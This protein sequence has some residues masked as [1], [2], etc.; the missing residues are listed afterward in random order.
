M[1]TTTTTTTTAPYNYMYAL[2]KR[3]VE[4]TISSVRSLKDNTEREGLNWL[5]ESARQDIQNMYDRHAFD[6]EPEVEPEL[7]FENEPEPE[8]E[9]EEYTDEMMQFDIENAIENNELTVEQIYELG[10]EDR[11]TDDMIK[12]LREKEKEELELE[13][14]EDIDSDTE[15]F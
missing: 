6:P 11:Y 2:C 4:K 5:I 8:P 13:V 15:M 9:Y 14:N 1:A 12:Q 10:V 3:E 7:E